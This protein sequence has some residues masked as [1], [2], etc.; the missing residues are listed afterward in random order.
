MA[1]RSNGPRF[2]S[3]SVVLPTVGRDSLIRTLTSLVEAGLTRQDELLVMADGESQQEIRTT[4]FGLEPLTLAVAPKVHFMAPDEGG[5]WGHPGRTAGMRLARKCAVMFTQDDQVFVPAALDK[6]RWELKE[7]P[8]WEK[9]GHL[10]RVVPRS[11]YIVPTN[12][13]RYSLGHVDADCIVLPTRLRP[14]YG[15]WDHSYNGDH[16][17]IAETVENFTEKG[18]EFKWHKTLLS[19]QEAHLE[20][21]KVYFPSPSA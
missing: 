12:P 20:R 19:V 15:T 9:C 17:F 10:F 1:P 3:L 6:L 2:I 7:D 21:Y 5:F 18:L 16:S 13:G 14:L 11:G 8:D 4:V